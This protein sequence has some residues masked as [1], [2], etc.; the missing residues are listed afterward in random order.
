M[1]RVLLQDL[2]QV[3]PEALA[4]LTPE[5]R[6]RARQMARPEDAHRQGAARAWLR[7]VLAEAL[8]CQPADVPLDRSDAGKPLLLAEAGPAFNL[9]HSGHLAALVL[10]L[11]TAT[12]SNM[13]VGIDVELADQS[14]DLWPTHGQFMSPTEA[15]W[16]ASRPPEQR[17]ALSLLCWTRKEAALK[18]WG[19][20]LMATPSAIEVGATEAPLSVQWQGA[21]AP[22]R[23]V[24]HRSAHAVISVAWVGTAHPVVVWPGDAA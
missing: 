22:C 2:D 1:L 13:Q 19:V 24:S 4:C 11:P 23:V 10:A 16:V 12:P 3:P 6:E 14:Q 17:D 8:G 5:E 7:G 18:A 9:S 15:A 21:T 20:G